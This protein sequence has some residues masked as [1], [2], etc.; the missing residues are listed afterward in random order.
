M[1]WAYLRACIDLNV[2][3]AAGHTVAQ[4]RT[5]CAIL[6]CPPRQL[7]MLYQVPKDAEE[8][9]GARALKFQCAR[10]LRVRYAWPENGAYPSGCN[11]ATHS[12]LHCQST[13]TM[14]VGA[15]PLALAIG[16][17][18]PKPQ[19]KI[20]SLEKLMGRR[21]SANQGISSDSVIR[22]GEE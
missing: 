9:S 1:Q 10:R 13:S 12:I 4:I 20:V 8:T 22:N 18:L 19:Y 3:S 6:I 14:P 5:L 17:K 15:N 16:K 7:V 11:L 21:D 2:I